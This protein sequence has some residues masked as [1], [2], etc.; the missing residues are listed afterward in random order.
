MNS[1]PNNSL[2][3][4]PWKFWSTM[5]VGLLGYSNSILIGT[6]F[7]IIGLAFFGE[8]I[9]KNITFNLILL[10]VSDLAFLLVIAVFLAIRE[11]KLFR[12]LA[13]NLPERSKYWLYLIPAFFGYLI[14]TVIVMMATSWLFPQIDLEQTQSIV[15]KDAKGLSEI[16]ISAVALLIIA[17]VAEEMVFRGFIFKGIRNSSGFIVAA[18]LSSVIFGLAHGQVNVAIDTFCLGI[19]LCYLYEKTG[20][21]WPSIALHIIKNTIAFSLIFFTGI[22]S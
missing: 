11:H 12:A 3:A 19:F 2:A 16:V 5:G 17:P 7:A 8:V 14:T 22:G 13:L 10:A 4:S 20:S 21:I 15:F 6:L 18:I 1:D 9:T